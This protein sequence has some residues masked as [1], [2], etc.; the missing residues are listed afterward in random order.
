MGNSLFHVHF[1]LVRIWCA[2][3]LATWPVTCWQLWSAS[4]WRRA[5]WRNPKR[6]N[7]SRNCRT[8]GATLLMSGAEAGSTSYFPSSWSCVFLV[9]VSFSVKGYYVVRHCGSPAYV[10]G[11]QQCAFVKAFFMFTFCQIFPPP[12]HPNPT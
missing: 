6:K 5:T 9:V 1:I 12:T 3:M 10:A 4:S 2:A 8:R 7:T 11:Y